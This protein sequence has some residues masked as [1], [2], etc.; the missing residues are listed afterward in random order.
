[1]T[2]NLHFILTGGTIDAFYN[3]INQTA[4]P[5]INSAIPDY[6][7]EY[8]QPYDEISYNQICMK[9]SRDITDTDR[10]NIVKDIEQTLA[11]KIIITHGTDTMQITAEY[12]LNALELPQKT[13]ILTGSMVPL[14]GFAN[15][16]SAFNLGYAMASAKTLRPGVYIAM[17]GHIFY[18]GRVT[19]NKNRARF[20]VKT[21]EPDI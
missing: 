6:L 9:D 3:A 12:I 18:A 7:N 1:M 20:E 21:D 5:N 11:N 10:A 16:D 19:K 14:K 13:I 17:H 2:T 15:N 4:T 8:I